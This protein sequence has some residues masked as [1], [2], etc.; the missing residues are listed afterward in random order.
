VLGKPLGFVVG[1]TLGIKL[2][3]GE[4]ALDG[5]MLGICDVEGTVLGVELGEP[6]GWPLGKSDGPMLGTD[7]G[8]KLG[9]S[10]GSAVGPPL[11]SL[12]LGRWDLANEGCDEAEGDLFDDGAVLGF[13]D[14]VESLGN[15]GIKVRDGIL[16][17]KLVKS[18]GMFLGN[19]DG[20]SLGDTL[21]TAVGIALR[22]TLVRLGTNEGPFE[23]SG[24]TA[25]DELVVEL[26]KRLVILLGIVLWI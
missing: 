26:G 23:S 24:D 13:A 21:L 3:N 22:G 4:K 20:S 2:G 8:K 15:D 7:D 17:E 25:V 18:V 11:R 14:V 5:Y 6:L 16:G 1:T 12:V 10:L 9:K 19:R